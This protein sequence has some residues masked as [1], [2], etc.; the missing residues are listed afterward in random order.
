MN[1]L[2]AAAEL[3]GA[4]L[5]ARLNK[6]RHTTKNGGRNPWTWYA[7]GNV[8]KL[9]GYFE[10]VVALLGGEI[11]NGYRCAEVNALVGGVPDSIHLKGGAIDVIKWNRKFANVDAAAKAVYDEA[12]KLG[13]PLGPVREIIP[14]HKTGAVHVD[15]WIDGRT[16]LPRIVQ[17]TRY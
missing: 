14:E 7:L 11:T 13:K 8:I 10:R 1:P 2:N 12:I 5:F 17:D 16:T 3:V 6:F 4:T 15:W 9:E